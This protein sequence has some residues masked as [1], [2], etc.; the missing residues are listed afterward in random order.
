MN[1]IAVDWS[2]D[3]RKR[4][5]YRAELSTLRIS[6]LPFDGSLSHLLEYARMVQIIE[7]IF[8]SRFTT[9]EIEHTPKTFTALNWLIG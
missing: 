6:R 4:S 9:V 3:A 2:L 5:A 1:I 8:S 7:H